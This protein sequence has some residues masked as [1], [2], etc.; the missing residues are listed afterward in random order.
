MRKTTVI[1]TILMTYFIF[2]SGLVFETTKSKNIS[3]LDLPYSI[4]LSAERTGIVGVFT[5]NDVEC[6]KWL[7][8]NAEKGVLIYADANGFVLLTGWLEPY[9][10]LV[11]VFS[12]MPE[13]FPEKSYVVL[14]EWNVKN[15]LLVI[16]T[17]QAG[18]RVYQPLP[19][20]EDKKIIFQSGEARIYR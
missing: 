16:H 15:E 3:Y 1:L 7:A 17:G 12:K 19:K 14:T 20:L 2:T 18:L 8:N 4:A 13:K 9:K 6:A 11:E 10:Q 5:E